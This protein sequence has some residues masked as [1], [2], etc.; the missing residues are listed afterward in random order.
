L[1]EA[2]KVPG[3]DTC[4]AFAENPRD[5]VEKEICPICPHKLLRPNGLL[6]LLLKKMRLIDAGK[7][8]DPD[9]LEDDQWEALAILRSERDRLNVPKVPEN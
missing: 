3:C 8:L 6:H 1:R 2:A 9:E 7:M 4:N 5:Y